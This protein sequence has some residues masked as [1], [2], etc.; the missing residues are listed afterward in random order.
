MTTYTQVKAAEFSAV[1]LS[2]KVTADILALALAKEYSVF[3]IFQNVDESK[4]LGKGLVKLASALGDHDDNFSELDEDLQFSE[5]MLSAWLGVPET[6]PVG[7]VTGK[8]VTENEEWLAQTIT[9]ISNEPVQDIKLARLNIITKSHV[10]FP[11]L[12]KDN[13]VGVIT[14]VAPSQGSSFNLI[15]LETEIIITASKMKKYNWEVGEKLNIPITVQVTEQV[16]GKTTYFR[17]MDQIQ[18]FNNRQQDPMSL[19]ELQKGLKD[20]KKFVK[21]SYVGE[22][23]VKSL[24]YCFTH[25]TTATSIGVPDETSNVML[26]ET[27]ENIF[28]VGRTTKLTAQIQKAVELESRVEAVVQGKAAYDK[29]KELGLTAADIESMRSLNLFA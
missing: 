9:S 14:I 1:K 10:R 23:S 11:T 20:A 25:V 4:P 26:F 21:R 16:A 3:E 6:T 29:V 19:D 27:Q 7:G 18:T 24:K 12:D 5:S 28:V 22:K 17:T 13:F 15:N 2:K 8:T